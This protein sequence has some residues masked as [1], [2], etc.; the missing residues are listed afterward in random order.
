MTDNPSKIITIEDL[1]DI[2]DISS[3][4]TIYHTFNE[5]NQYICCHIE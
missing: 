1:M 3:K 5:G 2:L 4:K